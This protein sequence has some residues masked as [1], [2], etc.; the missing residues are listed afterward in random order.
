VVFLAA[1]VPFALNLPAA[2]RRSGPDARLPG[3]F[4]YD[5]LNSVP[6]YG[7]LFTYGDNDT[8]PL[9]WAQEVGGIRRDVTVICLALAETE[10]YMRELRDNPVRPFDESAAPAIW[11]GRGTP[12]PDWPLHTMTDPEIAAA[13]PQ[14]LPRDVEL[15]VGTHRVRL[16]ARS[17]LYGKDFLSIRVIQQ[18]FGRRPI[19]WAITAG[20]QYY[21][22]DS[23]VLQQGLGLRLMTEAVDTTGPAYDLNRLMGAPLDVPITQRLVSETYR[24]AGLLERDQRRA[25]ETTAAGIASTLGLPFTQLALAAEA[26]GDTANLARFLE[27]AGLLTRNPSLLA[28]VDS[29]RRSLPSTRR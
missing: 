9:W 24:Y 2:N 12:S 7:I 21:G 17:A 22:L 20:G 15:P 27:S 26:R 10:W 11:K 13:V 5:L 23:L 3:D 29:I 25:L 1:L 4:A 28:R 6:P 14:I 8:F 16:K 18:N 19:V